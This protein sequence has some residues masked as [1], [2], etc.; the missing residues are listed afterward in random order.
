MVTTNTALPG[1]ERPIL[2]ED[3]INKNVEDEN[4]DYP[5]F[6]CASP[7]CYPILREGWVVTKGWDKWKNEPD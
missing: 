2:H 1:S 7:R 3:Y 6:V 5:I 4:K